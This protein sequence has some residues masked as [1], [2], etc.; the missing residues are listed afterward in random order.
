MKL[1]AYMTQL[2]ALATKHPEALDMDVITSTDDEGNGYNPVYYSPG[3]GV[4]D[5]SSDFTNVDETGKANG[6]APNCVC[7]N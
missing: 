4:F 2:S 7:L 3:L 1:K 6:Q 5:G